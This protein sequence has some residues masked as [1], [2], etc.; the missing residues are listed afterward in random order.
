[1]IETLEGEREVWHE[2]SYVGPSYEGGELQVYLDREKAEEDI[3]GVF[4]SKDWASETDWLGSGG[5]GDFSLDPKDQVV[6][7]RLV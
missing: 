4:K 3:E 7:L 5:Y 6:V 2:I 1:M